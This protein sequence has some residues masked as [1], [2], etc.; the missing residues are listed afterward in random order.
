MHS[1][2]S[3]H[4]VAPRAGARTG[5]STSSGGWRCVGDVKIRVKLPVTARIIG[6]PF[7]GTLTRVAFVVRGCLHMC[8]GGVLFNYIRL[9]LNRCHVHFIFKLFALIQLVYYFGG[10]DNLVLL[11]V[12]F[13]TYC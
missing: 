10:L 3:K 13:I 7:I 9:T 6:K 5:A 12:I 1:K 11:R 8:T 4:D 2:R